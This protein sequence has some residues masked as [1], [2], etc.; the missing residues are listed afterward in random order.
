MSDLLLGLLD[1]QE[2]VVL[3]RLT[4]TKARKGTRHWYPAPPGVECKAL[5]WRYIVD[6]SRWALEA[7]NVVRDLF[8]RLFA[9][10]IDRLAALFG[11][12][13]GGRGDGEPDFPDPAATGLPPAST[14]VPR[15]AVVA[16]PQP[17][18]PDEVA[19]QVQRRLENVAQ[20][21]QGIVEQV[22]QVIADADAA[23]EPMDRIAEKVRGTYADRRQ[24]WVGRIVTTNVVGAMNEASLVAARS[25]GC[26]RKQWLSSHDARVRDTHVKADG[27]I[28]P[29][30]EPFELGGFADHPPA[31]LDYP[32]DPDGPPQEV[33]NCRCT[34]LFP[35]P[36]LGQPVYDP[37]RDIKRFNPAEARDEHGRW[38]GTGAGRAVGVA[39]RHVGGA[40]SGRPGGGGPVHV[41]GRRGGADA[42]RAVPHTGD[43]ASA[44]IGGPAPG[45]ATRAAVTAYRNPRT[46]AGING[47]LRT[48]R[49]L[50][51]TQQAIADGL[52]ASEQRTTG[53]LQL[54]RGMVTART[55]DPGTVLTDRGFTSTTLRQ[56]TASAFAHSIPPGSDKRG[57]VMALHL[58]TGAR[59][60]NTGYD[61]VA[62]VILPPGS[63]FRVTH[64][65]PDG[66]VHAELVSQEHKAFHPDELR[67]R[68]GRWTRGGA[69]GG[70]DLGRVLDSGDVDAGTRAGLAA[71]LDFTDG[72]SGLASSV[73][74]VEVEGRSLNVES[75]IHDSSG[76]KVGWSRQVLDPESG[77]V[78][79]DHLVLDPQVQGS[80]FASRERQHAEDGYR[81]MGFDRVTLKAN[82]DVG[83]YAW[84]RAGYD[85][86]LSDAVGGPELGR[87]IVQE[88]VLDPFEQK[89]DAAGL[90]GPAERAQLDAA[91]AALESAPP[92]EWPTPFE[93]SRIGWRP[94]AA[95]WAGKTGMLGTSWQGVKHL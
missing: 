85:W 7:I 94:G 74:S 5:D 16:V 3:A 36:V 71:H 91:W 40:G 21:V 45:L 72:K 32:G 55:L 29:I 77:R 38:S 57:V 15:A 87:S 51:P 53:P 11:A 1:R 17:P 37:A 47:A 65:D 26:D 27:Q 93:L 79:L 52:L 33:I 35:L 73:R 24:G 60:H 68:L 18:D 58:P 43:V 95:E 31:R 62:E 76:A 54:Y 13:P 9:E 90:L 49:P 2:A 12:P 25:A 67:D 46:A 56:G 48:G 88:Y 63:S 89:A 86:D 14:V 4:G 34:L 64:V 59:A 8:T 92:E 6:P 61:D 83:G 81:A 82:I 78:H 75:D 10:V 30:G 20:G 39:A 22:Q 69:G 84:A 23:G 44:P 80:G 28:Q 19:R 70:L 50:N 41:G 66:V 42:A